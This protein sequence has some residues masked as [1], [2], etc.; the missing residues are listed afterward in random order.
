MVFQNCFGQF[1]GRGTVLKKSIKQLNR[2][3]GLVFGL[4]QGQGEYQGEGQF[5]G[6]YQA[7]CHLAIQFCKVPSYHLQVSPVF[8]NIFKRILR[9][10]SKII[11]QCNGVSLFVLQPIMAICRPA[12]DAKRR[13][14]FN[15][16]HF[17][18]GFLAQLA[19]G[20]KLIPYSLISQPDIV[21]DN[22]ISNA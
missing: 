16:L 13:W 1:E 18:V 8:F 22:V 12:P 6:Q 5:Y 3:I 19:S 10:L 11:F 7:Q 2:V 9:N 17:T 21:V 20:M 15:L 14:I 4:V